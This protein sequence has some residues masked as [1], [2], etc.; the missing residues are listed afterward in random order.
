MV[1]K[2]Y[3]RLS[4]TFIAQELLG[5]EKGGLYAVAGGIAP[6]DRQ[7]SSRP[8]TRSVRRCTICW[9]ICMSRCVFRAL[10][11]SAQAA[12]VQRPFPLSCP[13]SNTV[14]P[15][16]RPR[17]GRAAVLAAEWPDDGQWLH[18]HFIHAGLGDPLCQHDDRYAL[19]LLGHAP[20]TSGPRRTGSWK[21]SSPPIAGR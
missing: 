3:P 11:Q 4:E 9:N 15:Q 14:H 21:T 17:L 20:R 5:L 1:L 16:S 18:A 12:G 19:D 7:A 2:G 6:S 8:L 13:I 10:L